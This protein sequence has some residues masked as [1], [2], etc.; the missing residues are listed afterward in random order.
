MKIFW[1]KKMWDL[2]ASAGM[3]E[4]I[5]LTG[6]FLHWNMIFWWS[7]WAFHI[8]ILGSQI[9]EEK[10]LNIINFILQQSERAQ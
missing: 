10:F 2:T 8:K 7:C 1:E 6:P 4:E 3:L 9:S 5:S